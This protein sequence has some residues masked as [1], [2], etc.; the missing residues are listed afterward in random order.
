MQYPM[1][2]PKTPYQ[3]WKSKSCGDM[4]L[5]KELNPIMGLISKILL[6]ILGPKIVAL[7]GFVSTV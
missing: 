7:C 4:A 5:Q 1:L 3:V 6:S 2:L